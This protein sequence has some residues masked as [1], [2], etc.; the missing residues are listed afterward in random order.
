M[1][2]SM[3]FV[4]LLC[5]SSSIRAEEIPYKDY[6]EFAKGIFDGLVDS[7]DLES[8]SVCTQNVE[9][10]TSNLVEAY[11]EFKA[12][13]AS[14]ITRGVLLVQST[15]LLIKDSLENCKDSTQDD[16]VRIEKAL[17]MVIKPVELSEDLINAMLNDGLNVFDTL[18]QSITDFEEGEYYAAGYGFA[19]AYGSIVSRSV[20]LP[21]LTK[22]A[23]APTWEQDVQFFKGIFD[24]LVDSL[25]LTSIEACT[26][27][28]EQ[29]IADIEEAVAEYKNNTASSITRAALLVLDAANLLKETLE[30]CKESTTEDFEKLEAAVKLI[31]DPE[32]FSKAVINAVLYDGLNVYDQIEAAI[33]DFNAG[34]FYSAGYNFGSTYGQ[35]VNST[36]SVTM[37]QADVV[38]DVAKVLEGLLIGM[39]MD[40]GLQDIIDCTNDFEQIADD[41]VKAV[42]DFEG[43]SSADVAKG[44]EQ[45]AFALKTIPAAM[46]ACGKAG[47]TDIKNLEK[48]LAIFA[49]PATLAFE[50]GKSLILNGH[51]I[52]EEIKT[53]VNDWNSGDFYGF[54]YN[55]GLAFGKVLGFG[56]SKAPIQV[57]N[58]EDTVKAIEGVLNGLALDLNLSNISQCI[59]DVNQIAED[60]DEAVT[61]FEAKTL[62]SITQGLSKIGDALA[63]LPTDLQNCEAS[64]A[65]AK[66]LADALAIFK[67]PTKLV[68][69]IGKSL[70]LNGRE[71]YGDIKTAVSDWKS[72][73]YYNFGY[74]VGLAFGKVLS[75]AEED[76]SN[77]DV[78]LEVVEILEGVFLGLSVSLS[79]QDIELCLS[80]VT[81]I[82]TDV[83][84]AVTDIEKET[85]D[86]VLSGIQEIAE[87]LKQVPSAIKT[88]KAAASESADELEKALKAFAHPLTFI[89]DTGK[90]L[91]LDGKDIFTEIFTAVKDFKAENYEGFGYNVGLALGK[92]VSV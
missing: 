19:L 7:L 24:G 27:N 20:E 76:E 13:T 35:I 38:V 41:L 91:V 59:T 36:V 64:E 86:G 68:Y 89:Y 66:K 60:L 78:A 54:G 65:D 22:V 21:H 46:K 67:N 92:V 1:K 39:S 14:T 84:T 25:N 58:P 73:D 85:Y 63:T 5:F 77:D 23:A 81:S 11:E 29:I 43:K 3:L 49:D 44:L 31:T 15:A 75:Q 34:D 87:A 71:I 51:S 2:A 9:T 30:N 16:L 88:C 57:P 40:F 52:F 4:A 50:I 33:E 62:S 83:E 37:I 70:I 74:N 42:K 55:V 82:V 8:V 79:E 10:I 32:A 61:D 56:S 17:A 18:E 6:A 45:L 47:T 53:A 12:G 80:D 72:S 28:T 26:S 48:A 90:A 69:E